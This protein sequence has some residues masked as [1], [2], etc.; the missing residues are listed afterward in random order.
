LDLAGKSELRGFPEPESDGRWQCGAIKRWVDASV[1][2]WE[3]TAKSPKRLVYELPPDVRL[4]L[5]PLP[6]PGRG[7]RY[8]RWGV[9]LDNMWVNPWTGDLDQSSKHLPLDPRGCLEDV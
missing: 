1:L 6:S 5:R 3:A 7:S 8:P 9:Q 4:I 2:P